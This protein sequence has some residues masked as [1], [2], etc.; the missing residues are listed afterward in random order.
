MRTRRDIHHKLPLRSRKAL[1]H[2]EGM[3]GRLSG[4]SRLWLVRWVLDGGGPRLMR[5]DARWPGT[6][7]ESLLR[8]VHGKGIGVAGST[9]V[10]LA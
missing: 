10:R 1:C 2:T 5:A 8:G 4:S 7:R 3:R 9:E 6:Q